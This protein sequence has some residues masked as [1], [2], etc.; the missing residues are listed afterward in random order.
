MDAAESTT[1]RWVESFTTICVAIIVAGFVASGALFAW[2]YYGGAL[3]P[4]L[5]GIPLIVGL[6]VGSMVLLPLRYFGRDFLRDRPG[7]PP[8]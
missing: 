4:V 7:H 8:K 1:P 2:T 6:A 3:S 5:V